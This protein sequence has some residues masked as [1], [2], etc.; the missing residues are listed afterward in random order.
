MLDR[1]DR[2]LFGDE[3]PRR[4][5]V[6]IDVHPA[7]ISEGSMAVLFITLP[8]G[9]RLPTG[10]QMV[11][12][13]PRARARSGERMT[14]S[15]S[16]PSNSRSRS[17]QRRAALALLPPVQVCVQRLA[18]H[19]PHARVEQARTA[20]VQHHFRHASGQKHLHRREVPRPVRQRVHQPRNRAVHVRP[21]LDASAG[22]DPPRAQWP[23][24]AAADSSS[25]QTPRAAP[26]RCGPRR[27]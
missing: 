1:R 14:S 7:S 12:V 26:S 8:S 24:H 9:A 6:T 11:G 20:Q 5:S 3:D 21:V 13:S 2:G 18:G 17:L 23:E 19:R 10:K 22:A 16:M 4:P 27:P 25:R 15:A